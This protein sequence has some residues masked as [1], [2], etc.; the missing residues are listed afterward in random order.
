MSIVFSNGGWFIYFPPSYYIL[1]FPKFI[2]FF[3][4]QLFD[5]QSFIR[6]EKFVQS[7]S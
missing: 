7:S 2:I 4:S 5:L 3:K 1:M 6:K